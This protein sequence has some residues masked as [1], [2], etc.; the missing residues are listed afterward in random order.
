M[1]EHDM[2]DILAFDAGT[3][4]RFTDHQRG[5]LGGR[6]IFQAAAKGSNGGARTADNYNF[7]GHG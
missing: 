1:A 2:T 7:T 3:R 4:Q 5:Q 6:G